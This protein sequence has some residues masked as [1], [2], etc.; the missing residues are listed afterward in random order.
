MKRPV[1]LGLAVVAALAAGWALW[2]P[3]SI[4]SA[5]AQQSQELLSATLTGTTMGTR[6]TVKLVAPRDPADPS[7]KQLKTQVDARLAAINS[8]MSTWDKNSE[9]SLFN[10]NPSTEPI[11]VSAELKAI[12]EE[13]LALSRLSGGAFDVTVGPAV[14]AW[15]FG[16][17]GAK[18]KVPS[19]EQLEQLKAS[20]GFDKLTPSKDSNFIKKAHPKVYVDLSAIAKGYGVDE[21]A[22]VL[23]QRHIIRYMV[24]IGGEMRVSGLNGQDRPWRVGI[25]KPDPKEKGEIA[26]IVPLTNMA[27][28]TS[29]SYRNFIKKGGKQF[30]HTIDPKTLSPVQHNIV[31]VTVFHPSAML[32]DGLATALMALGQDK[33]L[34]LAKKEQ[35]PAYFIVKQGDEFVTLSTASFNSDG[36]VKLKL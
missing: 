9:L 20:V 12:T 26:R 4:S 33:G 14:N 25:E 28:A 17:K 11:K 31:S 10:K 30:S 36:K 16:P 18:G 1:V 32:A 21:V 23:D 7:F 35:I 2:Q 3:S 24:E 34:A 5:T 29:G 13:S 6:Y 15:G 27:V 19:K 22:K 8:V